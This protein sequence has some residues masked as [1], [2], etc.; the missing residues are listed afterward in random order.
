MGARKIPR[1]KSSK[2]PKKH[3]VV[4]SQKATAARTCTK[5]PATQM[6]KMP[7]SNAPG[8]IPTD[9]AEKKDTPANATASK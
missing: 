9:H 2:A 1:A 6:D 7:A 4:T 5:M 3:K 8:P